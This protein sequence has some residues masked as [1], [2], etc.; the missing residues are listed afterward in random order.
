MSDKTLKDKSAIYIHQE[1]F[2]EL[3]EYKRKRDKVLEAA[4]VDLTEGNPSDK[5]LAGQRRWL[6][7]L[8]ANRG[9][10]QEEKGLHGLIIIV[11]ALR[12]AIKEC[13]KE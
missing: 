3:Q 13:E 11:Q 12:A 7:S 9:L 1:V 2:D 10:Q 6:E 4:K 8:S 5:W